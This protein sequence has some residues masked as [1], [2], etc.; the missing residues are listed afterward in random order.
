M[1]LRRTRLAAVG[2]GMAG[3]SLFASSGTAEAASGMPYVGYGYQN[4]PAAVKC[5]QHFSNL[6]GGYRQPIFEDGK[7]GPETD[8][9]I[10]KFQKRMVDIGRF[11][12]DVDGI[13]GPAT[14]RAMLKTAWDAGIQDADY[15]RCWAALPS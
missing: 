12:L 7:Y 2:L 8:W 6:F 11:P 3:L 13:V 4:I 1:K 9:A 15:G 5:A 10:R 14:G